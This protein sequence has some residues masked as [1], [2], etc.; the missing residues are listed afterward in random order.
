MVIKTGKKLIMP[1]RKSKTFFEKKENISKGKLLYYYILP[2]WL[3]KR[4][5]NLKSFYL[6]KDRIC[7]YFSIEKINELIRFKENL[8][9][10]SFRSKMKSIESIK[11]NSNYEKTSLDDESKNSKNK[12][13]K[14]LN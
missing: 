4:N 14:T 3:L 2:L 13:V 9:E 1:K 6:I 11:I 7:G 5:K 8:E 12:N 10:K